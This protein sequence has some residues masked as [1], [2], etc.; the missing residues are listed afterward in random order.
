MLENHMPRGGPTDNNATRAAMWCHF[1]AS[2][3]PCDT[4]GLVT[5]GLA[6]LFFA[7]PLEAGVNLRTDILSSR[8]NRNEGDGVAPQVP[9]RLLTTL[10]KVLR[11]GLA[12]ARSKNNTLSES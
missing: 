12:R 2:F 9:R 4:R 8:N 3:R 10:P 7:P 1:C 11:G 6:M 5:L